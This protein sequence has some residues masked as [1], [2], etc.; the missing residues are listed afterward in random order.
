M[1]RELFGPSNTEAQIGTPELAQSDVDHLN[2]QNHHEKW[3][4]RIPFFTIW[5]R[6]REMIIYFRGFFSTAIW[7]QDRIFKLCQ[8]SW[9]SLQNVQA[10]VL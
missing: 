9:K 7:G 10:S 1:G 6:K 8:I 4:K 2:D 5:H 3:K